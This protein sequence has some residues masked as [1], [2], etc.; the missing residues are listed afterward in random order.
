MLQADHISKRLGGIAA[1]SHCSLVIGKGL[2]TGIIGPNGA[3]KST[4]FNVLG[5]LMAPDQG[6]VLLEG[7]DVSGLP[8]HRLAALGLVRTFQIARDLAELTVLENLLLAR[9]SQT[10]ESLLGALFR[11]A[12]V[13]QEEREALQK[14]S[15]LLGRFGLLQH[16]DAP[17]RSL[18]GGQKKLLEL[19]RALMLE[20][21]VILLD[22]PA[23]GVSP[24]MVRGLARI[25][26]EL[27]SEGLTFAIIEHDMDLIAELCDHVYVMAEGTPL[28]AGRF[29][30][31][32]ADRRVVQAYLGGMAP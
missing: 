15:A 25:I 22:E 31:V 2:V 24:V 19:A 5:G 26:G 9:P 23:A 12:R 3:G 8:P 10:G 18:S 11:P 16:A 30:E 13:R 20:P 1:L 27:R 14:A 29:A 7:R 32:T 17:A 6:R 28:T 4:L 21:K